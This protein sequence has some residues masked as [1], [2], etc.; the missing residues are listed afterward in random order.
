MSDRRKRLRVAWAVARRPDLW[1]T[2]VQL[3]L[4]L[5]PN[6]WWTGRILPP[7]EYLAYRGE[8]VYGMPLDQVPAHEFIQYLEWCR[9]FPGPIR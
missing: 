6:R 5:V 7:R 4:R 8:F 1:L 2:A 9:A 3:G